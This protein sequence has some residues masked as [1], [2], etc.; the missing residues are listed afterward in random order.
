LYPLREW[1]HAVGQ[2]AIGGYVY[3]GPVAELQGKYFYADF[4]AS[5]IWMLDFDRNTDPATFYGT[6]G[7]LTDITSLW[8]ALVIDPLD[9]NYR[10]DTNIA[11]L[12]GIDHVV[13]FGEDNLGNLYVV[14]FGYGASF[15]GQYTANAGEI[16]KLVPGPAPGPPLYWTNQGTNLTFSWPGSF[17][18]QAQT[19]S[20][21]A[22][23]G[24][25]WIDYAGGGFS[26]V[27][28]PLDTNANSAFFRLISK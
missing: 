27:S 22:G 6:N 2:A 14:D 16:F 1:S 20:A 12:N 28:V 4:V 25:N 18:L 3:R 23:L 24:S 13:S 26:P 10:G 7:I 15:A 17:K 19:N 11:T 8:S 5:R 9:V 21:G